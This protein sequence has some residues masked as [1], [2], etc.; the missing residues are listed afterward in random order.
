MAPTTATEGAEIVTAMAAADD[1]PTGT[2]VDRD[3]PVA[4]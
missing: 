1:G 4:W 3:G 2:F